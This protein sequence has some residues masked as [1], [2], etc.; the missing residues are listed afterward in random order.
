MDA[1][2]SGMGTLRRNPDLKFRQSP[3]SVA[4]LNVKQRAILESASYLL[5]PGGRLVYATCSLLVDENEA[6]VEQFLADHPEYRLMPM[7]EALPKIDVGGG[8]YLHLY[9][10]RHATDGFFAAVLVRSS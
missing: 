9:P 7:V 3:Q 6:I 5:K 1:P 10:H 2:C 8:D 4:E